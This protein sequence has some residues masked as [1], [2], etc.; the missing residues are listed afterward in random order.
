[1]I[2]S[3][4]IMSCAFRTVKLRKRGTIPSMS[5]IPLP[6]RD[7]TTTGIEFLPEMPINPCFPHPGRSQ[8]VKGPDKRCPD[9]PALGSVERSMGREECPSVR[10]FRMLNRRRKPCIRFG[11]LLV[12]HDSLR[13][14]SPL[15][16]RPLG[17]HFLCSPS[18][19]FGRS[20]QFEKRETCMRFRDGSIS[21]CL[22]FIGFDILGDIRPGALTEKGFHGIICMNRGGEKTNLFALPHT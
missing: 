8:A 16:I 5:K 4:G 2:L 22:T 10:T 11:F 9:P 19:S 17:D 13:S 12:S 7:Y 20:R 6:G 15:A 18:P 21:F 1:M 3:F 14:L